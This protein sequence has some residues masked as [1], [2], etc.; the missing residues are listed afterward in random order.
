MRAPPSTRSARLSASHLIP[1][2]LSG[3]GK[4][5]QTSFRSLNL[6]KWI[7]EKAT[8]ACS[9]KTQCFRRATAK[10]TTRPSLLSPPLPF[11]NRFHG[12]PRQRNKGYTQSRLKHCVLLEHAQVAFS[13][14]HFEG[15][16]NRNEFLAHLPKLLGHFGI[17]GLAGDLADRVEGGAREDGRPCIPHLI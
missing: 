14:A 10:L 5:A 8:W 9:N 16:S 3:L 7:T 4:C 13:A 15:C 2:F 6:S 12:G 11:S 1:K 17:R